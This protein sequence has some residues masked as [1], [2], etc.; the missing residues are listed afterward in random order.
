MVVY[1]PDIVGVGRMFMVVLRVPPA[2]EA[3][4]VT[5]H[6][7]VSMFDRTPLPTQSDLRKY[8]FRALESCEQADITFR[9]A[10]GSAAVSVTVWSYADL[11]EFRTLKG[12]QLPRR[13]PVGESLPELKQGRTITPES[14]ERSMSG[15]GKGQTHWLEMSDE[16][17]WS[18]QPD[19]TIPRWHW[20]NVRDGCPVHGTE[21]YRGRAFY[22]WLTEG[23]DLRSYR[24]AVPYRWKIK[25]PVGDEEYP[26]NDFAAGDMT[27]GAFPDDGFGGACLHKSSKY[28][29]LAELCQAY[30]H[31]MLRV[32]PECADSFL[33]T[34]DVRYVHK[35]LVALSRLATEYAYLATMTQHRHR[36]S[37]SQVDRLGPAP[38]SEGPCLSNSGFTVYC[39]DQPGY[40]WRCAETYDRIWPA[41]DKDTEIIPFLRGKGIEVQTHEDVRR[42]LEENL[43]A[44]WMQG[45]MD[46]AT[47]SNEPYAQRG[48]AR[49][50]EMLNYERGD[51]FLDWLYDGGGHMRTFVPNGFFR[52]G[53]PYESSGGYNGMHV[54]ALGPIVESVEHL[55]EL[56]PEVYPREK[57]PDLS[58]SRRYRNVFDFS[59]NTVTIDRCYPRVGDDG[60]HPSYGRRPRRTWQNG[61]VGAFE[62]AYRVFREPKFAWALTHAPGWTPSRDFPFSREEVEADA[63][64]WP[65]DWNDASCLQDGYGL[66]IVRSGTA[67]SKRALWMMYG[68]AR[69]HTHDDIMHIGFNAYGS[70]IL[71][72]V[73]YPRNWN[74]WEHCWTTQILARQ[75]PF[76]QMTATAQLLAD[77]GPVHLAEARAEGFTDRVGQG[78]GYDVDAENWQRR[79]IAI[80][81][82][83]DTEFYCVDLYRISGGREA[84]WT[85]H[86]QEDEGFETDGVALAKQEK[87]T[88]A[89][90]DVPYAD[91]A[92]LK[93]NGCSQSRVYGWRGPMFAFPHLYNVE[94]ASAPSEPWSA[95]WALKNA[96][97]MHFRLTVAEADGAEAIVCD[98][99]S[100][101]GASPYEMKWLLLHNEGDAPCRMQVSSLIE[102]YRDQPLIRSV[103]RLE[104]SGGDEAGFGAF[105]L[106]VELPDRTDTILAS[107][108]GNVRRTAAGGFE[109]AGRF[110]LY[111]E[112][113]GKPVHMV[114][115]GGTVL[116]RNGVGITSDAAAGDAV[117]TAV[118]RERNSVTLSPGPAD[119]A[120]LVGRYVHIV[121]AGRRVSLKVRGVEPKAGGVELLL[122]LDP[123]IG[124]GRV[125]GVDGGR[126]RTSTAF[127]LHRFRYYH[128]ARIVNQ[129]RTAEY[130][131][132]GIRSGAFA[133]LDPG[134]HGDVD[135]AVIGAEFPS[136]SWFDVYDYGVGDTVTWTNVVSVSGGQ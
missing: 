49:M 91:G 109:F 117:I 97:G 14:F 15:S 110:G 65:D 44:V 60:S 114:L 6:D 8:Y 74:Y 73:G 46:G 128:G 66:A 82:V 103:R 16:A 134:K 9:H 96:G 121:S 28:G 80:I 76:V 18:L 135:S 88:V 19:S 57:Y 87:G 40:Q 12:T 61:G 13:W 2:Q 63:A 62:H 24:A 26:S 136:G 55:R 94:R 27:S 86:A 22:P 93:A 45:A 21:I 37:R 83:S 4:E 53:A 5:A 118:D 90:P 124:T 33:R 51:E 104:V 23:G 70:E 58:E 129:A 127:P 105:G 75:I 34:G 108:D 59:M 132:A 31:Q 101:A 56:R 89:G 102:M 67:D 3:V 85:F 95:D 10:G 72:H 25:C 125:T 52:D 84:W 32:A 38:F 112:R 48:L 92:W 106:V 107:A 98:G 120:A 36:N 126:I 20:V 68:R 41:I 119:A 113:D 100:P 64:K 54:T 131:L 43:F 71:G 111:S 17:I 39:I 1:R 42:F 7:A 30:C 115:I 81:D 79:T 116:R 122:D 69:G 123:R 47:H 50:A 35:A 11:R 130:R 133:L 77:A 78:A 29:F 99:K